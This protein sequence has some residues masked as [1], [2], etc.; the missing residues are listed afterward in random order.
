M[1][2]ALVL[3]GGASRGAI[4]V[5][6]Y[7]AVCE[8]NI[9]F[10]FVIG[11][12]IGSING[13]LICSEISS[14]ELEKIWLAMGERNLFKLKWVLWKLFSKKS[15]LVNKKHVENIIN[16]ILPEIQFEELNKKLVVVA[17][18]LCTGKPVI[19]EEGN[20]REAILASCAIPGL[21]PPR[22]Y[23]NRWLIDGSVSAN[24]PIDLAAKF[25]ATECIAFPCRC[26]NIE[27]KMP[28]SA[29]QIAL[30]ALSILMKTQDERSIQL[31]K[32]KLKVVA[33]PPCPGI[34]LGRLDFREAPQLIN[35]AYE[36]SLSF[37]SEMFGK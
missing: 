6:F 2:L 32:S 19:F 27:V 4:E 21:F 12:S 15:S 24:M 25:G 13:A 1:P 3:C 5:G 35:F 37:L 34:E 11:S 9:K 16:Q 17:T 18:D 14:E 20:L 31:A 8:L 26:D 7:K 29:F 33:V 28:M 23:Q 22:F 10:D 30:R 36:Q